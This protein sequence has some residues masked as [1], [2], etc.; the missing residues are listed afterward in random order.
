VAT[1]APEPP[2]EPYRPT[3]YGRGITHIGRAVLGTVSL[4]GVSSGIALVVHDVALVAGAGSLL[5]GLAIGVY[6]VRAPSVYDTT[7]RLEDAASPRHIDA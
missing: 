2:A 6:A 1:A 4:A 3:R 5:L 7:L